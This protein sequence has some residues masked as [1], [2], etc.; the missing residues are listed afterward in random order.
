MKKKIF[1][2]ISTLLAAIMCFSL[3]GCMGG[4][5]GGEDDDTGTGSTPGGGQQSYAKNI[6]FTISSE[7]TAAYQNAIGALAKKWNDT[8]Y[9]KDDPTY[10]FKVTVGKTTKANALT[11]IQSTN[12][13]DLIEI[14]DRYS[15]NAISFGLVDPLAIPENLFSGNLLDRYKSGTVGAKT[16]PYANNA[17]LYGAPI[18]TSPATLFYNEVL[19]RN[20]GINVIYLTEEDAYE[21]GLGAYGY[22]CYETL[23]QETVNALGLTKT[24]YNELVVNTNGKLDGNVASK[25]GYRIFNARLP[26]SIEETFILSSVLT[27]SYNPDK[28]TI[29]S[30]YGLSSEYWFPFGWTVGGDCVATVDGN[31]EFALAN[32]DANY[33]V[34]ANTTINGTAYNAGEILSYADKDYVAKNKDEG[35]VDFSKLHELPSMS[36]IFAYFVA[37]TITK[38]QEILWKDV[39]ETEAKKLFT[40]FPDGLDGFGIGYQNHTDTTKYIGEFTDSNA[41]IL[42][43]SYDVS[44]GF[45][46]NFEYNVAPTPQYKEY[47]A[48]GRIK[49]EN[50]TEIKGYRSTMDANSALYIPNKAKNKAEAATFLAWLLDDAQQNA[51]VDVK[52]SVTPKTALINSQSYKTAFA[53]KYDADFNYEV[54]LEAATYSTAPDWC[55]TSDNGEWVN[56][57]S[58]PLNGEVRTGNRS[59]YSFYQLRAA[60]GAQENIPQIVNADLLKV[61]EYEVVS[62]KTFQ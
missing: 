7:A 6:T 12:A 21:A 55:Y 29:T 28:A 2:I 61:K 43:R 35:S 56:K 57:W 10:G 50:G 27:K 18:Q 1:S 53:A 60:E 32:S 19:F 49:I 24:T 52:F 47:D 33:L 26:M 3:V 17:V 48:N 9:Q 25:E 22:H 40:N 39:E 41:A 13:P 54:V 59:L 51:L 58:V 34:T 11:Q 23:T 16:S 42:Y 20:A 46:K 44:S 5:G 38:G 37:T 62:H 45:D 30:I 8:M 31:L 15:R 4:G 14:D 36:E